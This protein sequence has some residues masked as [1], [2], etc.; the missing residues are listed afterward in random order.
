MKTFDAK[1]DSK[2]EEEQGERHSSPEKALSP[3]ISPHL[4]YFQSDWLTMKVLMATFGGGGC[5]PGG[6]LDEDML[7]LLQFRFNICGMSDLRNMLVL[8]GAGSRMS[9]RKI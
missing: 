1:I 9:L 5:K 8:F 2:G 6:E 4:N 7:P 3:T